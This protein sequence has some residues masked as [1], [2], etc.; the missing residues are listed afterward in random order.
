MRTDNGGL[1]GELEESDRS[2]NRAVCL[3]E[4]EPAVVLGL[5]VVLRPV[6]VAEDRTYSTGKDRIAIRPNDRCGG[7]SF[8]EFH[9]VLAGSLAV[10]IAALCLDGVAAIDGSDFNCAVGRNR[11]LV[12]RDRNGNAVAIVDALTVENHSISV[13]KIIADHIGAAPSAEISGDLFKDLVAAGIGSGLRIGLGIGSGL[14][15]G[16]RAALDKE[17]EAV[18]LFARCAS[19]V[20]ANLNSTILLRVALHVTGTLCTGER[21]AADVEGLFRCVRSGK[22]PLRIAAR[23][24]GVVRQLKEF[25]LIIAG[26]PCGNRIVAVDEGERAVLIL[27][28]RPND[29]RIVRRDLVVGRGNVLRD[30]VPVVVGFVLDGLSVAGVVDDDFVA[31]LQL[32]R[33]RV[34]IAGDR[35]RRRGNI[36]LLGDDLDAAFAGDRRVVRAERAVVRLDGGVGE[37]L[38]VV[39]K[40]KVVFLHIVLHE[41]G[42]LEHCKAVAHVADGVVITGHGVGLGQVEVFAADLDVLDAVLTGRSARPDLVLLLDGGLDVGVDLIGDAGDLEEA[43]VFAV[44]NVLR[45]P[46]Q[47]I[48]DLLAG[49]LHEA[50]DVAEGVDG[51]AGLVGHVARGQVGT[52]TAAVH[53]GDIGVQ[54]F[55]DVEVVT[56]SVGSKVAEVG[57]S[58][59]NGTLAVGAVDSQVNFVDA[60]LLAELLVNSRDQLVLNG[61]DGS[62]G[63]AE[64]GDKLGGDLVALDGHLADGIKVRAGLGQ[65]DGVAF[66]VLHLLHGDGAVG[67]AVDEG[68]KAGGLGD[69]ILASPRSGGGIVAQVTQSDDIVG[70]LSLRGVDGSLHIFVQGVAVDGIEPVGLRLVHEVGRRRLRD[71]FGRGDTDDGDLLAADG[72]DLIRIEDSRAVINLAEVRRQVGEAALLGDL[73]RALHAVVELM[74]AE[75]GRVVTGSGHHLDD[76]LALI[77]RAVS[78]ALNVVARIEQEDAGCDLRGLRLQI[79]NV[80]VG[81]SLIDIGVDVVGVID[82][83][84]IVGGQHVAAIG[85]LAVNIGVPLGGDLFRLGFAADGAGVELLA[86]FGAG[87][88]LR[89]L[90][91]I[92]DVL[93]ARRG[94]LDKDGDD[95][96][97]LRAG[98]IALREELAVRAADDALGDR[99][100]EGV[101]GIG[102]DVGCVGEGLEI[103]AFDDGHAIEAPNH[104]DELLAGDKTL[105]IEGRFGNAHD[106]AGL[107]TPSDRVLVPVALQV[108]EGGRLDRRDDGIG[109]TVKNRDCHRTGAGAFRP[110]G[111]GCHAVHKLRIVLINELD[112][113]RKPVGFLNVRERADIGVGSERGGKDSEDHDDCQKQRHEFLECVFHF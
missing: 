9:A 48:E 106:D 40:D 27:L 113:G 32:S 75:G 61:S 45:A 105:R 37:A 47:S 36:G 80:V 86:L 20:T 46:F 79:G 99:P 24:V 72:E 30:Q 60:D 58:G 39:C 23:I 59:A 92:P 69:D 81:Q 109:K 68:V 63:A 66:L 26:I 35:R 41:L 65:D 43:A 64:A 38:D 2:L 55:G 51:L 62:V 8:F 88:L 95:L 31:V 50:S 74:V 73:E 16:R 42:V 28:D 111:G 6:V 76:L 83:D 67:V 5:V 87:R 3:I 96:G 91:L 13:A 70:V 52:D 21:S 33:L 22:I 25:A 44:A 54:A 93:G 18:I 14:R 7:G 12:V 53:D 112:I 84:L 57:L 102:A 71:G 103:V 17:L 98:R 77:E 107:L 101:A 108:G 100:V 15:I 34:D 89:H 56:Q 1:A 94:L 90:A 85:A 110:K 97:H 4:A 104:R 49:D 19:E 82:D 78:G 29:G 10:Q 11:D